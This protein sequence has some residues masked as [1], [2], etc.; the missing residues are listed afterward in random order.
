MSSKSPSLEERLNAYPQLKTRIESVLAIVE[1][2]DGAVKKADEAERRVIEELRRLGNEALHS[3][4][5]KQEAAQVGAVGEQGGGASAGKKNS[6]GTRRLGP[7]SWSNTSSGRR[8][9]CCGR[10]AARRA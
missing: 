9:A 4:A 3:W 8:G 7:S 10:F 2:A 5:A 6:T 1:D